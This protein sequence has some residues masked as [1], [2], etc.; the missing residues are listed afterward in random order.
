VGLG[1]V[2]VLGVFLVVFALTGG[3]GGFADGQ[4]TPTATRRFVTVLSPT[5]TPTSAPTQRP[6]T[7]TRAPSRTPTPAKPTPYV[8]NFDKPT[9]N[10]E[11][12]S[13]DEIT[14]RYES[15]K[16]HIV[17]D[18]AETTV[19]STSGNEFSDFTLEVEASQV[20]GPNDNGYGVLLRYVDSDNFYYF[21]IS[22]DG[23]WEFSKQYEGEWHTFVEWTK[24]SAI[25][26]GQ[27]M[28][29]IRV[30]CEGEVFT[31]FVNGTR[32]GEYEDSTFPEG[33]I[34]LAVSAYEAGGVDIAFDDLK[35]EPTE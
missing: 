3:F 4:T 26:Q 33:D 1:V 19:W 32:V 8:V 15:G 28:N 12:G 31:F 2:G 34:G 16:Y 10:W 35:V 23:Y 14:R 22:G 9:G 30:S 7:A 27:A 24:A 5:L 29:R 13:G 25:R 11:E 20:A 17:V 21:E 18:A 6:A